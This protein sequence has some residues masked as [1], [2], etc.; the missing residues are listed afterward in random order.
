MSWTCPNCGP[1]TRDP[2]WDGEHM[3]CSELECDEVVSVFSP[4]ER[5]A[6]DQEHEDSGWR[7]K[8]KQ[9]QRPR[10]V[11]PDESEGARVPYDAESARRGREILARVEARAR[12]K[13]TKEK[14]PMAKTTKKA[15]TK[16]GARSGTCGSCKQELF[17]LSKDP[18][19]CT[20]CFKRENPQRAGAGGRKKKRKQG[21][22]SPELEAMAVLEETLA[23]L[24]EDE[25]ERVFRWL[26]AR[27]LRERSREWK[28][29]AF[30]K[31][32]TEGCDRLCKRT[33]HRLCS[34]CLAAAKV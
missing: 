24:G 21:E 27:F 25:I 6:I 29:G 9:R 18:P 31:C 28:G 32:A 16:N 17:L 12:G 2:L 13:T 22:L 4:E 34:S 5:K 19:R 15:P 7:V 30:V 1:I 14:K 11:G 23:P 26:V 33:G 8:G 3:R 20:G 10:L